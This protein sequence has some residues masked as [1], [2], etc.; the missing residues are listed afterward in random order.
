[1]SDSNV[2]YPAYALSKRDM[3]IT[4]YL[5]I[6]PF[7]LP[8]R[9]IDRIGKSSQPIAGNARSACCAAFALTT[10]SGLYDTFCG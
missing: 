9:E 8:V 2:L 3:Y 10:T 5:R 1:M 6:V 4:L 7:R